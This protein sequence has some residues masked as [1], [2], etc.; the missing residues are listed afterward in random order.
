MMKSGYK[1]VDGNGENIK[2]FKDPWVRGVNQFRVN[3][4]ASTNFDDIRVSDL[5]APGERS[6]DVT[7][8]NSLCSNCD[9]KSILAMPVPK[10]QV[11]DHLAWMD[12]TDGR[13]TVKAGYRYWLRYWGE[14]NQ[15]VRH[16]GWTKLWNLQHLLHLFMDCG[17]AQNCWRIMGFDIEAS[18]IENC[19]DW[20]LKCL[21][22]Y[23]TEV[24]ANMAKVLWGIWSARNLR[25][26][27]QKNMTA[28]TAMQWS[29]KQVLQWQEAQK[30]KGKVIVE[31]DSWLSV[32][33]VNNDSVNQLEV[34]YM[35][36]E[37]RTI[38]R[39]NSD[40]SVS[41]TRKQ[42]NRVAHLLARV[43]C[44]AFSFQDYLS[45]PHVVLESLMDD[46]AAIY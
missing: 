33:A 30:T 10:N 22:D 24:M 46:V 32:Q 27:E 11:Q 18:A 42:A 41:F 35:I 15:L 13:Y 9:A 40:F 20:V 43:H 2:A 38:L 14:G 29:N 17:F 28:D 21:A 45:P 19:N 36:Q 31:S 4:S 37:S 23:N 44:E 25:V 6:W 16:K 12:S 39:Q 34:G 5:L 7:K 26:W 1:W 3:N 8:V